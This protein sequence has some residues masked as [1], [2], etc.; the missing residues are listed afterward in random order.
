MNNILIRDFFFY[1]CSLKGM[2]L[3]DGETGVIADKEVLQR[4]FD[5]DFRY[6][7]L[8]L[9]NPVSNTHYYHEF[10]KDPKDGLYL[11]NI[12]NTLTRSSFHV[13]IDTRIFPNFVLVEKDPLRMEESIEVALMMEYTLKMAAPKYKWEAQLV[14]NHLNEIRYMNEFWTAMIYADNI[15]IPQLLQEI[16][17]E[18][19]FHGNIDNFNSYQPYG[20]NR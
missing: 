7:N 12:V 16:H 2:Q 20:I 15:Y 19:N 8:K 14:V 6:H 11:L 1:N 18:N 5:A 10:V 9:V 3:G 17:I 4:I 13:L